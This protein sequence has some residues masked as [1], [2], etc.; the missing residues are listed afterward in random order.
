MLIFKAGNEL[1]HAL[2]FW[3]KY[4]AIVLVGILVTLKFFPHGWIQ[5]AY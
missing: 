2:P 1:W 5:A 3:V 4:A